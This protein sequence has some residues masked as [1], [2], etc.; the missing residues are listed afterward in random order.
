LDAATVQQLVRSALRAACGE[1]AVSTWR[2]DVRHVNAARV[3]A[4]LRCE[5][6]HVVGL[7]AALTLHTETRV[8]V[9]Q[10]EPTLALIQWPRRV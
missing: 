5:A 9:L 8:D 4:V 1:L 7:R 3:C 10:A 6:A 2:M